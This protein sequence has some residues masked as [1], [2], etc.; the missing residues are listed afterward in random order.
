MHMSRHNKKLYKIIITRDLKKLVKCREVGIKH[1]FPLNCNDFSIS[2]SNTRVKKF[3]FDSLISAC[4]HYYEWMN[5]RMN[6][7]N[8]RYTFG[9]MHKN[10]AIFE[11]KKTPFESI[12]TTYT[13]KTGFLLIFWSFF[14]QFLGVIWDL[15]TEKMCP[16]GKSFANIWQMKQTQLDLIMQGF[17]FIV[18]ICIMYT[19]IIHGRLSRNRC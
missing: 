13:R 17:M 8:A 7:P 18:W 4:L 15:R 6:Q 9:N 11:G 10:R 1:A 5:E 2:K 16:I 14:I 3:N 19:Y 12:S